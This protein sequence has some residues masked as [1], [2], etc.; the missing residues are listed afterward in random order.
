MHDSRDESSRAAR[1]FAGGVAFAALA[2]ACFGVT[3]PALERLGRGVG[4]LAAAGWLYAGA[5]LGSIPFGRRAKDARVERKHVRRLLV[6]A[7]LG[8]V[9]APVCLLW[10]LSHTGAFGASLLLNFEAP[11]TVLLAWRCFH[12]PIGPRFA[13]AMALMLAGGVLLVAGGGGAAGFGWGAAGVVAATLAWALDNT[14]TRPLAD[15][16]P[17]DVVFW[18][19]VLGAAFSLGISLLV[20]QTWPSAAGIAGFSACGAVGYGIS[21]RCY[22]L[23]QRRIGAARTASVFALAPFIG[24]LTAW[25]AGERPGVLALGPATAL[26]ALG[27]ALHVAEKHAHYH[28]HEA[29]EH[30]HAHRHDDG[31]HHHVHDPPVVGTHS[32]RHRHEAEGHAHPHGPDLHH[33]HRHS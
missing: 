26:F 29:L 24:A 27:I 19:G 12:E 22:L 15:L 2:A 33:G 31:H 8:A 32:H 11:F 4:P 10:G 25:L 3:T 7:A 30:E 21:L 20:R 23:A 28:V 9:T 16:D 17:S 6:V 13:A 14:L 1:P 5:A 18:K